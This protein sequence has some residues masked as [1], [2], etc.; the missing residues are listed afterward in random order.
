[1]A[2]LNTKLVLTSTDTSGNALD[3]TTEDALTVTQPMVDV[4][5]TSIATG[6]AQALVPSNSSFSYVYIK[7]ISG[8]NSTDYLQV[9]LGGDVKLKI[10]V[11]EFSWLPLYNAQA[12]TA[13]AYGG[14]CVVEYGYW[15][16]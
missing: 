8:A 5:R 15:S 10:R 11:G 9:K 6:S 16:V 13:E 1:M 2:T 3:L 4:A 7:V 14:A 12:I